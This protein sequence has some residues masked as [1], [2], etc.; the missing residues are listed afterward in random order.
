MLSFW[1][2]L[3]QF[4]GFFWGHNTILHVS[5]VMITTLFAKSRDLL[6]KIMFSH[7]N[8]SINLISLLHLPTISSVL[9]VSCSH[10]HVLSSCETRSRQGREECFPQTIN[11]DP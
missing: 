5:V 4:C 7:C 3:V 10:E 11:H 8:K 1:L 9:H 6:D 2:P